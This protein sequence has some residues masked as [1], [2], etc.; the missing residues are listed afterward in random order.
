ML[1]Y[2]LRLSALSYKRNPILSSLMVL[3]V[4]IGISAYMVIYTLN[5]VMGGNPIPQKSE[6]L[7]HVQL[8]I[9]NPNQSFDPPRQLTYLDSMALMR[10]G[11]ASRQTM[12]SKFV[13][14]IEPENPELR[15]FRSVGRGASADFFAMF[16]VPF[17]YGS[18]WNEDADTNL[19][20][21]VVLSRELNERLYGG[22]DSTGEILNMEGNT[23]QVLGVIDEWNPVPKY[24]DVNN[25]PFDTGEEIYLPWNLIPSLELSRAG[26][27]SCHKPVVG[28]G[29][30]AFLNSEC[31]WIQYWVE[32]ETPEAEADYANFINNYGAEQ[33]QLGRFEKPLNNNIL[34]VEEWLIE[35]E[36]LPDE[37]KILSALAAMLLA[38]CL[39]N[40]IGLLLSKFLSKSPEIGVRQALGAHKGS[41]FIQHVI[42]AGFIGLIGG[43]FGA[44]LAGFGL[45]GVKVLL[46]EDLM[47]TD[48]IQL[49]LNLIAITMLMAIMSTIVAG[50]YPIWRACNVNPAIHLKTQ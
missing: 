14:I 9:G 13:G 34:D 44:V 25:G 22:G 31:V 29:W 32:L 3:A 19:Q 12:S 43:L 4:A 38:V 45:E 26:N 7:F 48:W 33:K 47:Q 2:Y 10:D 40:T 35:Q 11:R 24:Y 8:D 6:Q 18:S 28:V 5:Y 20:Q 49:D 27:T 41:L 46:G 30:Q 23:F 16:D 1:F 37:T 50:L 17:L 15:P 42:E 21:V 36:V 39:L